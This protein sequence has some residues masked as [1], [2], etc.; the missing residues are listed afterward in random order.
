MTET[1]VLGE[2]MTDEKTHALAVLIDFENIALGFVEANGRGRKQ[3]DRQ[4]GLPI[5]ADIITVSGDT[6]NSLLK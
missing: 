6:S 4:P 1:F 5:V 3:R 2:G